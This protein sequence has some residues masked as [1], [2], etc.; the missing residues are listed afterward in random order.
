MK[1]RGPVITPHCVDRLKKPYTAATGSRLTWS[2]LTYC[3]T[4]QSG[5]QV[6][7]SLSNS[8]LC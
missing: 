8:G 2:T 3:A 6:S 1:A 7:T 5:N 4:P